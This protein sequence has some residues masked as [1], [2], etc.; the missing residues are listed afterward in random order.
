M[1]FNV[2]SCV[3]SGVYNDLYEIASSDV[4]FSKLKGSTV[5]VTGAYGFLGFYLTASLLLRNDLYSDNCKVIA[6]VRNKE[7][8]EQRFGRLLQRDDFTLCVKDVTKPI[9]AEHAD[10]I[11]HAAGHADALHF[12]T[13]PAGTANANLS[14]TSNVLEFARLSK[15]KSVLII[16]SLKIYGVIYGD[17]EKISEDDIGYIDFALPDNCY[18]MSKRAAETLAADYCDEFG[19]NVKIARPAYIYGAARRGDD[20]VWAQFFNNAANGQDILLKSDGC[21]KRSFIYITDA[22]SALFTILLNG[23]NAVPYNI[24]DDSSNVTIREFVKKICELLPEKSLR[25]SFA[26]PADEPEPEELKTPLNR[27][28]DV[29]DSSRLKALGWQP[30]VDLAQGIKRSVSTTEELYNPPKYSAG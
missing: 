11:I 21:A 24:A 29:L 6:L 28:P 17:K 4:D 9:Q 19:T 8:A 2:K 10:F 26:D 27:L 13:D 16:S 1:D 5:L 14:G 12:K 3:K 18:A 7:K 25:L 23:E 22:V 30:R 20:R 15:S